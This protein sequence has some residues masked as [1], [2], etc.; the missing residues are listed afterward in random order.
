MTIKVTKH[1]MHRMRERG[2]YWGGPGQLRYK[3]ERLIRQSV[4]IEPPAGRECRGAEFWHD[5]ISELVWI[6]KRDGEQLV[7]LTCITERDF[8]RQCDRAERAA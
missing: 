8:I 6:V 3:A 1:A 7:V 5:A 4:R 2:H